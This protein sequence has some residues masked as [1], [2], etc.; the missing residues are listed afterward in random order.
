M[1]PVINDRIERIRAH[2]RYPELKSWFENMLDRDYYTQEH[3]RLVDDIWRCLT[4]EER[5]AELAGKYKKFN[6]TE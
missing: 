4:A 2:R 5:L 6:P 3:C 1:D